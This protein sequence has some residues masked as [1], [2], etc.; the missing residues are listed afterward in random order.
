MIKSNHFLSKKRRERDIARLK[1]K[2]YEVTRVSETIINIT[3][4][5]PEDTPYEKGI[6]QIVVNFPQEYPYKSPSIGFLQKIYHP[7]IDIQSGSICLDVLNQTWTPLYDVLNIIET[8]IP[9]LLTYPNPSDPLNS[10]AAKLFTLC[11]Q[12]YKAMVWKYILKHACNR[13]ELKLLSHQDQTTQL[14]H[15]KQQLSKQGN[16]IIE[17]SESENTNQNDSYDLS[18]ESQLSELSDISG[19]LYE[20]EIFKKE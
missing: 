11:A 17:E 15:T 13:K 3:F 19:L 20:D 16:P 1:Q 12:K 14:E 8:F 5:G 7:N 9:Q 4:N 2:K 6:W 18:E 10:E